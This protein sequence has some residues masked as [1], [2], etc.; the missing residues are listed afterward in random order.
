MQPP[1]ITWTPYQLSQ[2]FPKSSSA[3]KAKRKELIS[4]VFALQDIPRSSH[5]NAT[6]AFVEDLL[7]KEIPVT[8]RIAHVAFLDKYITACRVRS[9]VGNG[10]VNVAKAKLVPITQFIE[11]NN[12]GTA[13]CPLH[14]DKTPS[15]KYYKEQNTWWCF[16][17]GQGGDV[18]DL[19][20]KMEGLDFIGAVK[21]LGV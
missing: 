13:S 1:R 21:Q 9:I 11:V 20:M 14:S 12:R 10:G 7:I 6:M 4:E 3:A 16:S 8:D 19:V 18:I 5:R 17:C 2:C 15:F